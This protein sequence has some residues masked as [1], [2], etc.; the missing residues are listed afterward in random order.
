MAKFA[1]FIF[2]SY[3]CS[4]KNIADVIYYTYKVYKGDL[5]EYV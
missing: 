5:L 4:A 1:Y 2:F 3:L